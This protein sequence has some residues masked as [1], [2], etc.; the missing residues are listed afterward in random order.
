MP[1]LSTL[2]YILCRPIVF[3]R[4]IRKSSV[5]RLQILIPFLSSTLTILQVT[6]LPRDAL[7]CKARSC[8]RMSSVP[9]S[10]TLVDQDQIRCKSLK[11]IA[12]T[13]S[14]TPSLFVAKTQST[15]SQGNMGNF[16]ET[17]GGVGKS[18]VLQDKS[19]NISETHK[20]RANVTMGGL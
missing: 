1:L 17:R 6:F 13:I 19:G 10:V 18:G 11:L 9:L 3:V 14:P 7:Q 4:L 2:L 8:D 20:Y 15:Y 5:P 16:E 12:R